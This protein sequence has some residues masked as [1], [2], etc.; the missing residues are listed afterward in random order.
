MVELL[1]TI[2]ANTVNYE[3]MVALPSFEL[4]PWFFVIPGAL[5]ALLALVGAAGPAH[6]PDAALGVRRRRRR[7]R[8]RARSPCSCSIARPRARR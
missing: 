8:R 6:P 4:F 5:V 1:D 2:Q 7:A 3:A